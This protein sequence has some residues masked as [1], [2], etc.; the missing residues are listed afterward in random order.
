[1]FGTHVQQFGAT[2]LDNLLLLCHRHHKHVHY[3][4][5]AHVSA[6]QPAFTDTSRRAI[7]RTSHTHRPASGGRRARRR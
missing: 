5:H 2:V 1:V 4:T 3:H 6:E 7:T